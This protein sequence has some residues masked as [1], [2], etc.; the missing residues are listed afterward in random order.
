MAETT[1][2][3]PSPTSKL[4]WGPIVW[5][6]FHM[7]AEISTK[8]EVLPLWKKWI[9]Q[10]TEILPCEKCRVHLRQYLRTHTFIR[11]L[12]ITRPKDFIRDHVRNELFKLHNHV[13]AETEKP[14]YT[15]EQYRETYCNKTKSE[16]LL[17]TLNLFKDLETTWL[18]MEYFHFRQLDFAH[19][20]GSFT[21]L[22]AMLLT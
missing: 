17:E 14:Q 13:N 16:T 10:T 8:A 9:H 19:W 12:P 18:R 7:M 11:V 2:D 4:S 3:V 15:M 22:R 1:H 20:K 5:K 21:L 6:I